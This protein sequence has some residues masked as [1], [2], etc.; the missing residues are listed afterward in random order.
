MDGPARILLLSMINIGMH[1]A[2]QGSIAARRVRV[3]TTARLHG[4]VRRLLDCLHGEI[5]GRLDDDRPLPTDPGD[6]RRPILVIMAPTG[7]AF[8]P[9]A[10]RAAPQRLLAT[11]LR[12]PLVPGGVVE[13]IG[14][15]GACHLAVG[16]VGE[17]GI[18]QP[19]APAIARPA[20]H[21]QFS[22][23]PSRGTR[24][25]QQKGRE[26][27]VYDRALAA[28]QER[29]REVIEGALAI[30]LFTA[31]AFQAGLVVVDA[32]RTD[33]VALTPR[34]L[35]GPIFPAQC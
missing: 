29:A 26:N 31:V 15:H 16:F 9:P 14:F 1:I 13:V 17:G 5:A 34:T 18:A 24:Q 12:L 35:E 23:N 27:P 20:M 8:L 22:R 3:E 7:L 28:V 33:V 21:P 2:L 19:P 30:L 25:A 11:A 4:E 10:T 32:P 6:N